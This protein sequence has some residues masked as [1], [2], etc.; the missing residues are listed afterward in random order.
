MN[1][2]IRFYVDQKLKLNTEILK[3]LT[4]SILA[5]MTG[6]LSLIVEAAPGILTGKKMVLIFFGVIL[7]VGFGVFAIFVVVDNLRLLNKIKND[8]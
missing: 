7:T 6:V 3:I 8:V 1:D 5:T 4:L 2:N